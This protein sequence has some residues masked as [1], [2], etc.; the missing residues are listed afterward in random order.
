MDKRRE[1]FGEDPYN[2]PSGP[3][4]VIQDEISNENRGRM[5]FTKPKAVKGK[6]K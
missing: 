3:F 4:N 5:R 1:V 6:N 2:Y